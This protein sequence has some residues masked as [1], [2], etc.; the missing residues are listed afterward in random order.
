MRASRCGSSFGTGGR[1]EKMAMGV[2]EY[3]SL[4]SSTVAAASYGRSKTSGYYMGSVSLTL[5]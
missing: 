1:R 3:S 5:V 4:N 2:D